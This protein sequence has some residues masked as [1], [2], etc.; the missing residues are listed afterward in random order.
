M[1][2]YD[3]VIIIIFVSNSCAVSSSSVGRGRE[4]QFDRIDGSVACE[5]Q[6]P[7]FLWN[8]PA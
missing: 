7:I 2:V 3:V 8:K 4:K 1:I 6:D 5:A